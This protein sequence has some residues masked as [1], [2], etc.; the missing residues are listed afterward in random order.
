MLNE[1]I[2][3]NTQKTTLRLHFDDF[4]DLETDERNVLTELSLYHKYEE[5]FNLMRPRFFGM[6]KPKWSDLIPALAE[7]HALKKLDFN[8]EF[9]YFT[10]A[11]W[12]EFGG[13]LAQCHVLTELHLSKITNLTPNQLKAMGEGLSQC[14]TL[15]T[16]D[17]DIWH[18]NH[19]EKFSSA[20]WRAF[21]E[22]LSHCHALTRLEVGSLD[23]FTPDNLR[24]FG[25]TLVQ[26]HALTMLRLGGLVLLTPDVLRDLGG[27]L[28][29]CHALTTLWFSGDLERLMPHEWSILAN[30]LAQCR[31]LTTLR[32]YSIAGLSVDG[33][34]DFGEVLAHCHALTRLDLSYLASG[35]SKLR[36]AEWQAFLRALARCPTLIQA[37][38]PEGGFNQEQIRQIEKV[39]KT[40]Q[41]NARRAAQAAL[42][43]PKTPSVAVAAS[44]LAPSAPPKKAPSVSAP[45]PPVRAVALPMA[46][47]GRIPFSELVIGKKLGQGKFGIVCE[48][49]WQGVNK[50]AVK[51]LLSQT[52]SGDALEEFQ[53]EAAIHAQ[54]RHPNIIVLYGV[55]L[56]HMKYTLVM[57]LMT[58]GS[59][60]DVLHSA[61]DL[62]WTM[63]INIALDTV[64]GLLYLHGQHILHRDLK[65]LNILLDKQ[66]RAKLSDFGLS[67]VKTI[68]S[69]STAGP[70]GTVAWM[71]PEL[72]EMNASCTAET[73]V[74]AV[75]IVFWEII[76]RKLPYEAAAG[77]PMQMMR[78]VVSGQRERIPDGT[79]AGFA[80][81]I[82][83]CWAQRAGD[84]PAAA[85]IVRE[86]QRLATGAPPP[87]PPATDSGYEGLRRNK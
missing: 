10:P 20:Q 59:L 15:T 39:L 12:Q 18:N 80:Q 21:G 29:Q 64:A 74:Y 49:V 3:S 65:S 56:E 6:M 84:R 32:L 2:T 11:H 76:S 45:P 47:H 40:N 69:A 27:A 8:Y 51:Q 1:M 17:F 25:G 57:E 86:A 48:A 68:S 16:L 7:C 43:P 38:D 87:P 35:L 66:G 85:E 50:V 63:R 75:G 72:F 9:E 37:D 36:P 28:A 58:Q 26:C 44:A 33:W 54:L 42:L 52:L 5:D 60:Y 71:A 4:L 77:N 82:G 53:R 55:C 34:S 81:L 62:P 78:Y 22:G 31:A 79:P 41:I 19:M 30:L 46:T 23:K 13:T 67:K 70:V 73:D 61:S 83:R 14:R 24:D